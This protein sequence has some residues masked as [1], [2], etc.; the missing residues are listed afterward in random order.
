MVN[1]ESAWPESIKSK[2]QI[3]IASIASQRASKDSE[4]LTLKNRIDNTKLLLI[5]DL[6]CLYG[7]VV[8]LDLLKF[9]N[10]KNSRAVFDIIWRHHS[11]T[12]C[13]DVKEYLVSLVKKLPMSRGAKRNIFSKLVDEFSKCTMDNSYKWSLADA[14]FIFASNDDKDSIIKL[15]TSKFVDK[16]F[17]MLVMALGKYADTSNVHVFERLMQHQD[18]V[19]HCIVAM[20]KAKLTN[21]RHLIEPHLNSPVSWIRRE[22]IKAMNQLDFR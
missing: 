11:Q 3:D 15:L 20:R 6:S 16:S 4:Y 8:N 12:E 18:I 22:A 10:K 7:P 5:N 14:I 19:G 1:S 2:L 21:T 9:S 17:Q 13:D